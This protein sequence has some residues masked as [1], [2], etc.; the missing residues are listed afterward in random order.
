[1]HIKTEFVKRAYEFFSPD[2]A[3]YSASMSFLT[4]FTIIPFLMLGLFA[5]VNFSPF[6]EAFNFFREFLYANLL[7]ESAD[8]VVFYI[9]LFLQNSSELG[10]FGVLFASYTVFVFIKQLDFCIQK[11]SS[12]G[13]AVFGAGRFFRYLLV[14]FFV[15]VL[16]LL[17]IA[18]EN[19]GA[20]FGFGVSAFVLSFLQSWGAF[21]ALFLLL[22]PN[23]ESFKKTVF[24]SFFTV[25]LF[26]ASKTLFSYYIIFSSSYTTIYG[27]FASLFWFFVWLNL[28]WYLFFASFKLYQY[29]P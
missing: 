12:K 23:R 20:F 5:A 13:D 3:I 1:M 29:K 4:V 18:V 25:A 2:L 11:L 8:T 10:A 17:S 26:S 19:V 28:S 22:S 15:L 27:S 16:L 21:L 14:G 9:N 6:A 24:I 7:Q